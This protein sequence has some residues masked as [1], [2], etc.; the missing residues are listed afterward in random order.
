[1]LGD[2]S[3]RTLE[4]SHF[5]GNPALDSIGCKI[6]VEGYVMKILKGAALISQ[7]S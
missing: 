4:E 6:V 3:A 2:L 7:V 5:L 1:M